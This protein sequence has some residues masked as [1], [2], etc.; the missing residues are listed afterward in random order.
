METLRQKISE[1]FNISKPIKEV[2]KSEPKPEHEPEPQASKEEERTMEP[3]TSGDLPTPELRMKRFKSEPDSGDFSYQ[4]E[5]VDF[6][7]RNAPK[8]LSK[9][10]VDL[11][12]YLEVSFISWPA[13]WFYRGYNWQ[14]RRN[15]E[16]IGVYIQRVG[17]Y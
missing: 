16:R 7:D 8:G 9:K 2:P 11:F 10:L 12:P 14:Y 4:L 6:V 5:F 17:S 3:I 1:L 15:T 13:Y